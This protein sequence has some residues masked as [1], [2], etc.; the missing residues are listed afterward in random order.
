MKSNLIPRSGF[1]LIWGFLLIH[2]A[3][4]QTNSSSQPG[5]QGT[6]WGASL[7]DFKASKDSKLTFSV[8]KMDARPLDYL[9]MDFHEVDKTDPARAPKFAAQT[10][11]GDDTLYI[12]Y[13]GKLCAASVTL[14]LDQVADTRH[15]LN[16]QY[17]RIEYHNQEAPTGFYGYYGSQ[18]IF[19]HHSLYAKDPSTLID[20]V[21]VTGY[22][23]DNLYY[24]KSGFDVVQTE[25]GEL[26][27]AYLVYVSA[28]YLKG[29][30]A[31]TDWQENRK[32][33]TP[34]QVDPIQRFKCSIEH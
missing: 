19:F 14:A 7:S 10:I 21:D 12:F 31:Y 25:E 2:P 34:P 16:S 4:A 28:D 18:T 9:L 1:L 5:Y 29:P 23:D 33:A 11:P 27:T 24:G 3:Y 8:E 15:E 32:N 22:Y 6:G 30:N 26:I 17:K 13:D 20:L